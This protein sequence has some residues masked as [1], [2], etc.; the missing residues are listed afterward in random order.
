MPNKI[1]YFGLSSMAP[2]M[3]HHAIPEPIT[4]SRA[5]QLKNEIPIVTNLKFNTSIDMLNWRPDSDHAR[6][7]WRFKKEM[8][9]EALE[10]GP[11]VEMR[12]DEWDLATEDNPEIKKAKKM[13]KWEYIRFLRFREKYDATILPRITYGHVENIHGFHN[14]KFSPDWHKVPEPDRVP[15]INAKGK[16][17]DLMTTSYYKFWFRRPKPNRKLKMLG[18]YSIHKPKRRRRTPRERK[19]F[20]SDN[21]SYKKFLQEKFGV[22]FPPSNFNIYIFRYKMWNTLPFAT[23]QSLTRGPRLEFHH[24]KSWTMLPTYLLGQTVPFI[25]HRFQRQVQRRFNIPYAFK[26]SKKLKKILRFN[27]FNYTMRVAQLKTMAVIARIYLF[28]LT[29][30]TTFITGSKAPLLRSFIS[31]LVKVIADRLHILQGLY[32]PF[33]NYVN[34]H[35]ARAALARSRRKTMAGALKL[36][37]NHQKMGFVGRF[38]R[39]HIKKT[40]PR[41]YL[42]KKMFRRLR[43]VIRVGNKRKFRFRSNSSFFADLQAASTQEKKY[44]Q[45]FFH[46]LKR[47]TKHRRIARSTPRGRILKIRRRALRMGL[48]ASQLSL[49]FAHRQSLIFWQRAVKNLFGHFSDIY[50]SRYHPNYSK[51]RL[52]R[53]YRKFDDEFDDM[54]EMAISEWFDAFEYVID[55]DFCIYLNEMAKFERSL[56]PMA[57]SADNLVKFYRRADSKKPKLGAFLTALTGRA[58]QGAKIKR[59]SEFHRHQRILQN[60]GLL[61]LEGTF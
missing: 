14:I 55:E 38:L 61:T 31:Q 30:F 12:H 36:G 52:I 29:N 21:W 22:V 26:P 7:F 56:K 37:R 8:Y 16:L 49:I 39:N 50:T 44:R 46:C 53:F 6:F 3:I 19:P 25:R 20:F 32:N 51:S 59:W 54:E 48:V 2:T 33:S 34:M 23:Q 35:T 18:F 43:R 42:R 41:S 9:A 40:R 17:N 28:T 47:L 60:A 11:S 57:I 10:R 45:P 4:S 13:D 24:N 58:A 5:Q 15:N 1:R 27:R